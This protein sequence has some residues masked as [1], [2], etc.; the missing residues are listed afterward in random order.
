MRRFLLSPKWWVGHVL[1][2]LAAVV[3]VALGRWQYDRSQSADGDFQ[4]LGYALQWPL[5]A[6]FVVIAWW[7]VLRLEQRRL[8]QDRLEQDRPEQD[9]FEQDRDHSLSPTPE[10]SPPLP[11]APHGQPVQEDDP[12]DEL[13]AYNAHLAWLAARDA[14]P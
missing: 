8:E 11:P 3:F 1:V 12:D 9:R 2:V 10:P 7:R 13:A 5:F 14:Q 4:N 6:V